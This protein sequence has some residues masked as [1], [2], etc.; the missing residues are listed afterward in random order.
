MGR[1]WFGMDVDLMLSLEW[2]RIPSEIR[3]LHVV[4]LAACA[5]AVNGGV[6][7]A[8]RSM[9]DPE[10]LTF[11][12]ISVQSVDRIVEAGLAEWRGDDL[13][14]RHYDAKGER[15]WKKQVS[16]GRKRHRL[17]ARLP[18]KSP[19]SDPARVA[20]HPIPSPPG[21]EDPT[22]GSGGGRGEGK[23]DTRRFTDAF[24]ALWREAAGTA[25]G[26]TWDAKTGAQV[27]RLLAKPGGCDEAIRRAGILF[28]APPAWLAKGGGIPDLGTL[29]A[30]WDKLAVAAAPPNGLTVED[31][32]RAA[33]QLRREG[34]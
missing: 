21:S 11:A 13:R 3:G 30:H 15:A 23:G 33:E 1:P 2:S 5:R 22:P 6:V 31:F 25:N 14:V 32:K 27:K 12:C 29:V 17:P 26:P 10:W 4:L 19:T 20:S 8:A 24:T 9:T 28:R 16:G 34:R 18:D 7:D